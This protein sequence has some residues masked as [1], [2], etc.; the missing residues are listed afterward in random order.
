MGISGGEGCGFLCT[1]VG[2]D[3]EKEHYNLRAY[4]GSRLQ[5]RNARFAEAKP[6]YLNRDA[7]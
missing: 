2:D 4:Q 1:I 6:K 5:P 3:E 7:K